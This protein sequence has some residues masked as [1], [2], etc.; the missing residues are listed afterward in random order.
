VGAIGA[1]FVCEYFDSSVKSGEEVEGL[2]QLPT[3][4][5]VPNFAVARRR[6]S[7]PGPAAAAGSGREHDLVMLHEP[8]SPAAEAFR[9]LRTAVLFSAPD[10]PPKV[11]MV[12]SAGAGEGKTSSCLNLAT[13]LAEAGSRVVVLDVDLRRPSCHRLLGLQ[14][15]VGPSSFLSGQVDLPGVLHSVAKPKMTFVPA[16]PMPPNP[17]E[18]VGSVRMRAALDRLRH[19]YDFVLLDAPPVLPV[20]DAVVLG[21]EAEGVVLVVKGQDTP[22]ELVRRA[23][24]HLQQAGAHLLGVVVNNVD[25]GWSDV[26]FYRQYFGAYAAEERA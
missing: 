18:L 19:D 14:N 3:L 15:H 4:A 10:A 2:L 11:I 20:T 23:R 13:S 6:M 1:A 5:T 24:D 22:R 26:Y 12:T 25:L 7:L 8:R 9:A 21:R 16:G 17:A